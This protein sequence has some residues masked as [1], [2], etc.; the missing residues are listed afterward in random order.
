MGISVEL[1]TMREIYPVLPGKTGNSV[2]SARPC[3]GQLTAVMLHCIIAKA[4]G[5]HREIAARAAQANKREQV[6]GDHRQERLKAVLGVGG[7]PVMI[8]AD[9]RCNAPSGDV[10]YGQNLRSD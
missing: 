4:G 9:G 7:V 2:T 3:P 5:Y 10:C 8:A 6:E 1:G